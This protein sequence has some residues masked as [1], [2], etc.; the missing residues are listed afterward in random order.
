MARRKKS[1]FRN[2][3]I[4]L[5]VL[6]FFFVPVGE[7]A[8]SAHG[9]KGNKYYKKKQYQE[10]YNEYKKAS[11]RKKGNLA[12]K[13]NEGAALYKLKKYEEAQKSFKSTL[14]EKKLRAKTFYNLGNSFY[15]SGDFLRE[16]F[17]RASAHQSL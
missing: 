3:K 5:A 4:I 14:K 10:A 13:F 2:E 15:K 1:I 6:F 17:L 9:A 11:G 7:A 16:L 8:F 12:L